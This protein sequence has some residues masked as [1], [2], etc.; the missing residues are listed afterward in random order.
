[1]HGSGSNAVWQSELLAKQTAHLPLSVGW[2]LTL[3]IDVS[4]GHVHLASQ[5]QLSVLQSLV[6]QTSVAFSGEA[7]EG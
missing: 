6:L 1:M 3:R 2:K 5:Q 4:E 7:L